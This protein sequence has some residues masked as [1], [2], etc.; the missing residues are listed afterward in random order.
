LNIIHLRDFVDAITADPSWENEQNYVE[1][2]TD[3]NIFDEDG[4]YSHIITVES[5]LTRIHAYLMQERQL[6]CSDTFIFAIGSFSAAASANST[7]Q[8]Q[9]PGSEFDEVC[10]LWL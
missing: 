10:C 8:N 5:I 3:I 1:I 7:L 4:F 2:Q 6:Y 9:H